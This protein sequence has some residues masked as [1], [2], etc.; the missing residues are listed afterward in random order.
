M[1]DWDKNDKTLETWISI[2]AGVN[3]R[4]NRID[5]RPGL[6]TALNPILADAKIL[7]RHQNFWI[8]RSHFPLALPI[9]LLH[10][11]QLYL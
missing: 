5:Q 3:S 6:L 7:Q 2:M 1:A 11:R 8:F 4:L 10:T 9:D